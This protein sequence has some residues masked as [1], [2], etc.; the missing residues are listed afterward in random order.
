MRQYTIIANADEFGSDAG[1][2]RVESLDLLKIRLSEI[3]AII[4]LYHVSSTDVFAKEV[5]ASA[6]RPVADA[7]QMV[8]HPMDTVTDLPSGV[9]QF[10]DRVGLGAGELYSTATNS[11]ESREQRLTQTA[12]ETSNITLTALG[13]DQ[14]RRKKAACRSL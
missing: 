4:A 2:Y 11:S 5:A 10:F 13:Y 1:T 9:G 7:A 14:L 3:P 12:A 6:A 8:V